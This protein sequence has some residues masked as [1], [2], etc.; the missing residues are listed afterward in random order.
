MINFQ[1]I[2]VAEKVWGWY[3]DTRGSASRLWRSIDPDTGGGQLFDID[4]LKEEVNSWQG[5]GKTVEAMAERNLYLLVV[6]RA[7]HFK[8]PNDSF[9]MANTRVQIIDTEKLI[10]ATHLTA[11]EM[12]REKK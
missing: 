3:E 12:V 9:I 2:E 11:L 10:E 5:F 6:G 7:I 1:Y 4:E 8:N